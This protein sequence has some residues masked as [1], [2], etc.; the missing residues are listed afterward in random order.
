MSFIHDRYQ[1][2]VDNFMAHVSDEISDRVKLGTTMTM[3]EYQS[4]R[5]NSYEQHL[6]QPLLD[7]AALLELIQHY[8]KNAS[9]GKY[10]KY[11]L[12]RSYDDAL[13]CVL[14]PMLLERLRNK[15]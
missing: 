13:T 2:I 9:F 4:L 1:K 5:M 10:S 14:I 12:P 8:Y 11:T 6:I 15:E 3:E 7:K